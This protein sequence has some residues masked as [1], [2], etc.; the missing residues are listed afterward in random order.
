MIRKL[1]F[2]TLLI[3][4]LLLSAQKTAIIPGNSRIVIAGSSYHHSTNPVSE[5]VRHI[6][7]PFRFVERL[8]CKQRNFADRIYDRVT[9]RLPLIINDERIILNK[10]IITLPQQIFSIENNGNQIIIEKN[11]RTI[12]INRQRRI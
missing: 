2:A 10:H 6:T 5:L 11:G 8:F 7:S 1:L 9:Y 4:P 3:L 12:Y